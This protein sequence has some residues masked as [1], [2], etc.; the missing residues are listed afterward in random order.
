[1]RSWGS[2]FGVSWGFG[3]TEAPELI[4]SLQ[5]FWA[6]GIATARSEQREEAITGRHSKLLQ[7]SGSLRSFR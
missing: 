1:M 2:G 3:F 4:E 5:R 7:V 6:S